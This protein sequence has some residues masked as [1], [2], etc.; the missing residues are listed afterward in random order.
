[1]SENLTMLADKQQTNGCMKRCCEALKRCP[2]AVV[3]SAEHW[4]LWRASD[5]GEL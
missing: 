1:M 2:S 4:T 3:N 5:D